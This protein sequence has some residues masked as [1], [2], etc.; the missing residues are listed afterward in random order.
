MASKESL[1]EFLTKKANKVSLKALEPSRMPW[2]TNRNVCYGMSSCD[3]KKIAPTTV[4]L[5]SESSFMSANIRGITALEYED[6]IKASGNADLQPLSTSQ[7]IRNKGR[8][9]KIR[10]EGNFLNPTINNKIIIECGNS[11]T[12]YRK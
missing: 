3:P 1:R 8:I 2:M 7:Y 11:G 4:E 6:T 12:I 5:A 9:I 10:N